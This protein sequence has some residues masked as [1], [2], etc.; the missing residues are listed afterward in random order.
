MNIDKI[1]NE[2]DINFLKKLGEELKNQNRLA[3]AKP[4][5]WQVYEFENEYGYD[6]DYADDICIMIGDEFIPFHSCKEALKF[7]LDR[8]TFTEEEK[9]QL[10]NIVESNSSFVSF[11]EIEI[12][13]ENHNINAV[14]TG[15]KEKSKKKN[16]FLTKKACDKHIKQNPHHYEQGENTKTFC[17]HAWRNPELKKLLEIIEKFAETKNS[18][19]STEDIP[20]KEYKVLKQKFKKN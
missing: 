17:N 1:L 7:L 14:L 8:Y 5:F 20:P 11:S 4:V 12:W 16:A 18:P 3:T 15:Y 9:K 13:C 19:D 10:K 2:K 6:L